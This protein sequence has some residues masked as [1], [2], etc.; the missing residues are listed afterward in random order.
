VKDSQIVFQRGF[1]LADVE[2]S[3]PAKATTVYRIASVTK[4]ITAVAAMQL[5]E[6]GR[7]DL[8]API[9]KYVPGFPAKTSPISTRQ[10]LTHLSGVRHYKPGEGERTNHYETLTDALSIFKDDPLEHEPGARYTYSTYGYTLVGAIIEGASG[11][12]FSDYLRE[13]VFKPAGMQNTRADDVY[14]LIPNR[15]RG[16][17]P[18]VYARFD[19]N[20]RNASLMDSSYKLPGGGLVSTAEDLARFAIAVQ[21]GVLVKQE[22]LDRMSTSQKTR[23]GV[24]T[25]YGYGWYIEGRE[26][27]GPE[28]SISHG[29]VQSGFTADLWI[30]P[31]KRFA[32]VILA[33][34]EGGGRLGLA[35]LASKIADV[36]LQ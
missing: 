24:E 22:T 2:N 17:S 28:G 29:G 25:G 27:R 34:L 36:V 14:A 26:G 16:Y 8:D 3:V 31:R 19:G 20:F 6:K 21:S 10:L 13:Q 9:Q 35:T 15:A 33:N 32:V 18:T 1:G 12:T 7:I 30:L 23:D 11:M 4:A 5:A